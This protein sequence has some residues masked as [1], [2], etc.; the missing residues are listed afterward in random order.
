MP[1][2]LIYQCCKCKE[3]GSQDLWSISRDHKYSSQR[4]VCQHFDVEIDHESKIGFFFGIGWRNKIKVTAYYKPGCIR[5]TILERT[6]KKNDTEYEDYAK[7]SNEAVFH[8]RVSDYRDRQ[9]SC[10]FNAQNDID[11]N[12][13][14]EQERLEELRRQQ[15]IK[16]EKERQYKRELESKKQKIIEKIKMK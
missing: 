6:F 8:A 12:E 2:Y 7:F 3:S 1:L 15:R 5:K 9:P 13:R 4:Y 16:E 10:G 14:R 11:Y